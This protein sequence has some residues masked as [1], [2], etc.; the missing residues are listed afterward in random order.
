[1]D[2]DAGWK[3]AT[4]GDSYCRKAYLEGKETGNRP[5]TFDLLGFTHYLTRSRKGGENKPQPVASGEAGLLN[6]IL[7]DLIAL[8]AGCFVDGLRVLAFPAEVGF[9]LGY[10]ECRRRLDFVEARKI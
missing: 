8:N 7:I 6:S 2:T 5:S 3:S 10:K 4:F 9:C 1:M